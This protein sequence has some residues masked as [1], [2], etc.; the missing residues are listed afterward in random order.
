MK[1]L[2]NQ[3]RMEVMGCC[4]LLVALLNG[5]MLTRISTP[6]A[7]NPLLGVT[8][9]A[10]ITPSIRT[11]EL[12]TK[13][14]NQ[15]SMTQESIHLQNLAVEAARKAIHSRLEDEE[16]CVTT[17]NRELIP[18]AERG[19]M[20]FVA[21]PKLDS[22][23]DSM[24]SWRDAL[25]GRGTYVIMTNDP[26]TRRVCRDNDIP[27]ICVEHSD[28]GLPLLDKM[29]ERMEKSQPNGIIGYVNSDI[30]VEEF[31]PLYDFLNSL[32][33]KQL[34]VNRPTDVDKPYLA[35]GK[36]S[37][38][39]LSVLVRTDIDSNG[40]R[41]RHSYGGYDFW[42][43]NTKPGGMPLLPFDIPPFR[44]PFS[45]YDN[46]LL[47]MVVQVGRR[48]VIDASEVID[49]THHEHTRVGKAK[50]WYEALMNGVTGVYMNR[51]FAYNEP[52]TTLAVNGLGNG[53]FKK[54]RH[55]KQ[56]GT[57]LDCPYYVSKKEGGTFDILKREYWTNLSQ[58]KL[59][60][61]GCKDRPQCK[62]RRNILTNTDRGERDVSIIPFYSVPEKGSKMIIAAGEHW[63]YTVDEQLKQHATEDGFVLL[64]SVNYAYREH[65]MNF[66]C[67]L[68]RVGM[69]D[70]FV[71]A[72]MD[73]QVY[74]WGVR[75]GLPI[76]LAAS[77][78]SARSH[79]VTQG[80]EYG[81]AGFKSVTKLK[82]V[83]VL[84]VLNKGYS[85]IWSDVDITWFNHPFDALAGFMKKDGGIAI[86][87]NA[88]YVQNPNKIAT[89][90]ETVGV[91][92]GTDN[93]A[94]VR[95]L[96]SGLYVAPNNPLVI[97]AFQEIVADAAKSKRTEQP[98]FDEILCA[99]APSERDYSSCTYRP[100]L[101]LGGDGANGKDSPSLHV[102]LLDR[103]K[104]PNGA[105]LVGED[106]DNVY[107]LGRE[108]FSE[109][110]GQELFAAHNNWISGET[111]KKLRQVATGWWFGDD[112]FGCRYHGDEGLSVS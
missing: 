22:L 104:F 69:R 6:P 100:A 42:A 68:E 84:E 66:K 77:A 45:N 71:V 85:V 20:L 40:N 112:S 101:P 59:A 30:Y 79:L 62:H 39:W 61:L 56:F 53:P 86:Q 92:D 82:S 60:E 58:E 23:P 106:N 87:S 75:R 7:E 48:N 28:E 17:F 8:M 49:I 4:I 46:W 70:H 57:P 9:S 54:V 90:H 47:D 51:H 102:E 63:R 95:R 111:Q 11:R 96:N 34:E 74:E 80:G 97:S 108:L 78:K 91:V 38:F 16:I 32:E 52:R 103:F 88:P 19:L 73:E 31:G 12:K 89:P 50:S 14:L 5:F 93:P 3:R 13:F 10:D 1:V 35:T 43:W 29:F 27:T 109:A 33:N 65:L 2:V 105:V 110:T 26:Q 99:R 25:K 72:A 64:T 107:K 81:G 18:P 55:I 37:D 94:A 15:S 24:K 44:F 36:T 41:T 21:P 76:Y 67:T 83:A 98:S